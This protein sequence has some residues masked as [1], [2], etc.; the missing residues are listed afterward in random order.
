MPVFINTQKSL[1]YTIE[2]EI[3]Q[4]YEDGELIVVEDKSKDY[5]LEI[6]AQLQNMISG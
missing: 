5:S 4:T 3:K 6:V 2:S 1:V